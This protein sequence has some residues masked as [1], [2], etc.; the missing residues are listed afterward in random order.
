ML[1]ALLYCVCLCV[2]R[3]TNQQL[4]GTQ[5]QKQKLSSEREQRM[6]DWGERKTGASKAEVESG[7]WIAVQKRIFT[8]WANAYL[9]TRKMHI[10]ELTTD[11]ADGLM[12]I[13]LTEILLH[14]KIGKKY[15]KVPKMRIHKMENL[16]T[17][18]AW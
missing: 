16:K 8:R 11:L 17:C 4:D 14:T 18:F 10:E 6:A 3:T 5:Q 7:R 9:K 15:K 12:L 2:V 1:K 13:N